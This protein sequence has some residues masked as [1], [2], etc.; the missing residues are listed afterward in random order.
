MNIIANYSTLQA[1]IIDWLDESDLPVNDL[2]RFAENQ[3]RRDFRARKLESR[4]FVV[5]DAFEDLP[6]DYY[7]LYGMYH[8]LNGVGTVDIVGPN[9]FGDLTRTFRAQGTPRYAQLQDTRVQFL[10]APDESYTVILQYWARVP[11]LSDTSPTNWM[12]DDNP[13]IYLF[14][15]LMQSPAYIREDVR[16]PMW[17]S[18]YEEAL[19]ELHASTKNRL[20]GGKLRRKSPALGD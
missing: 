13:D 15:S 1:A 3:L 9:E 6:P 18:R 14:G 5:D 11:Y 2:I 12:I 4:D 19:N 10:P 8:P 16:Y 17:V 20:F 7:A